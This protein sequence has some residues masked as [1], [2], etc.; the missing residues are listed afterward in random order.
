[1]KR[2][3]TSIQS[4]FPEYDNRAIEIAFIFSYVKQNNI[5]YKKSSIICS[6]IG[7]ADI[8]YKCISDYIDKH[9]ELK[10]IDELIMIFE[11]LIDSADK[12]IKGLYIH[13]RLYENIYLK[14]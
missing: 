6:F 2:T 9:V 11:I 10:S 5:S 12:K 1:M 3:I 8:R 7:D 4:K 13:R 14:G